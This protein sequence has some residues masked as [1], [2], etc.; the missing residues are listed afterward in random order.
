MRQRVPFFWRR[1]TDRE[2][3]VITLVGQGFDHRA[4]GTMLGITASRVAMLNVSARERL[5][6]PHEVLDRV[7]PAQVAEYLRLRDELEARVLEAQRAWQCG[8]DA[9][10]GGRCHSEEA[11]QRP[12][13]M[14]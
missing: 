3:E 9:W 7:M 1:L 8:V 5:G 6:L 13:E 10:G 4:I 2:R 12:A 14:R 11:R